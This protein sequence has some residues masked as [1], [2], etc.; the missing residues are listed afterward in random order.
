V[1]VKPASRTGN[2]GPIDPLP[3]L[4]EYVIAKARFEQDLIW[5]RGLPCSRQLTIDLWI[6]ASWLT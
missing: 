1:D 4:N 5:K 6:V 3:I 2:F